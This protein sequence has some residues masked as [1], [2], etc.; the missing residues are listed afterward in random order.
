MQQVVL[1]VDTSNF[2]QKLLKSSQIRHQQRL[3][4]KLFLRSEG[5]IIQIQSKVFS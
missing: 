3:D 5:S 2:N 4:W 1:L